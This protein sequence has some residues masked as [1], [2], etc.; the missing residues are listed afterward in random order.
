MRQ[1]DMVLA[2]LKRRGRITPLQ[3]LD[4]YGSLR[5]GAIIFRLREDYKIDT[6][7]TGPKR[8]ATYVYRGKL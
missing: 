8:Y 3:A 7:P 2:H 4:L 1:Q 5:L 6:V